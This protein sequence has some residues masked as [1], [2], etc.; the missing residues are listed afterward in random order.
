MSI[1]TKLL[2]AAIFAV[3]G[4]ASAQ[5]QM[6]GGNAGLGG[7]LAGGLR[8]PA[9]MTEG[10]GN[11]SF[12]ADLDTGSLRHRARETTGN[13]AH[14]VRGTADSV[15][16]GTASRVQD[17]HGRTE[18][19]AAAAATSAN[20]AASTGVGV[21]TAAAGATASD[22][23][24]N[25]A[26]ANSALQ[27]AAATGVAGSQNEGSSIERPNTSKL[28]SQ[29][30]SVANTASGASASI[31]ARNEASTQRHSE[32]S[33]G[34]AVGGTAAQSIDAVP[35]A[36][37]QGEGSASGSGSVSKSGAS[38]ALFRRQVREAPASDKTS[39]DESLTP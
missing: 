24:A 12:G 14:R 25:G 15:H 29:T 28:R 5:A 19:V 4:C 6:L 27:G 8:N 16:Q 32:A 36:S 13:T 1:R 30:A 20:G 21:T 33:L 38:G 26:Q 10:A 18:G 39:L 11:G 34:G 17:V 7:S 9:A 35:A 37:L 2:P 23:N 22:L 31:P 3:L